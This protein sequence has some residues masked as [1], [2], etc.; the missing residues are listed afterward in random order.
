MQHLP[1]EAPV[2]LDAAE[3]TGADLV[4]GERTFG[5]RRNAGVALSRE[6]HRQPRPVGLSRR[7]GA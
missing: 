1:H 2:L 7:V 4:L 3:Q 6:P 5:S